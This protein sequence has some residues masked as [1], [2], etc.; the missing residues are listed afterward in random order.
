[1]SIEAL[2]IEV[3]KHRQGPCLC[4]A[5]SLV[6]RELMISEQTRTTS[7]IGKFLTRRL[8]GGD[9]TTDNSVV[10]EEETFELR[11]NNKKEWAGQRS[12]GQ[13]SRSEGQAGQA[14]ETAGAKT[15]RWER[16]W[17]AGSL[18]AHRLLSTGQLSGPCLHASWETFVLRK[19]VF[20]LE[21]HRAGVVGVRGSSTY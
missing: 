10:C 1:M 6:G 4:G 5:Y 21:A 18:R 15:W 20:V 12:R 7:A 3:N 8:D 16:A 11:P 17:S 19:P 13:R 9:Q 14:E 2:K